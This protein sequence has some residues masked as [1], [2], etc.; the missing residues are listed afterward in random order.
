M[1]ASGA[2]MS[3]Q[4][5]PRPSAVRFV[6]LAATALVATKM[7]LDRVCVSQ[8]A[9]VIREGLS[10]EDWQKDWVLGA[11][12]WS[13]ALGQVPAAWLGGRIGFRHALT[14]Y[15]AVWSVAT[16]LTGLAS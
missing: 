2:T 8:L 14:I 6:V 9:D 7:Y 3:E 13:Y 1:M 15:L 12:F 5:P 16:A 10:L 11:F 4:P